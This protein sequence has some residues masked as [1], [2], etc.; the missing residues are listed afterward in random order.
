MHLLLQMR[1][2]SSMKKGMPFFQATRSVAAYRPIG[3]CESG[4]DPKMT[5]KVESDRSAASGGMETRETGNDRYN[6]MLQLRS[7]PT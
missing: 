2:Q 1:Q 6:H 7:N 5:Q 3:C 4:P